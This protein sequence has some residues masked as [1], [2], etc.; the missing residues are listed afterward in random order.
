MEQVSSRINSVEKA[1]KILL[2]FQKSRPLWGVRD[3][4]V[5]LGF[6]PATVQRILQLLKTHGFVDQ[7]PETRQYRLGR[8]YYRFVD[9]LQSSFP[10]ARAAVP[11]MR[12]LSDRT[13]ETVHLNV[14]EGQERICIDTIESSQPLKASMPVGN[15]SPLY[16]GASSKC[17]LAFSSTDFIRQYLERIHLVPLTPETIVDRKQLAGEL[18]K[19]RRHGVALSLGERTPGLGSISAPILNHSGTLLAALSL[20]IPE[21][22]YRD[23]DHRHMSLTA[24][25]HVAGELSEAM[26]CEA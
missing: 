1:L 15:R 21:L 5:H 24:L 13:R 22:R 16:A 23:P 9:T 25:K 3:L 11:Y 14:V 20:A 8:I 10:L 19:I 12:Q 6:S 2:A 17:L 18:Q 7:D 4:S 26:G